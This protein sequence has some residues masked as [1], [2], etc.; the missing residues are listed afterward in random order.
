MKQIAIIW[1]HIAVRGGEIVVKVISSVNWM[2]PVVV[3]EGATTMTAAWAGSRERI[4]AV[5]RRW[6]MDAWSP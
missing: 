2:L 6:V 1:R 5:R 3:E 4:G